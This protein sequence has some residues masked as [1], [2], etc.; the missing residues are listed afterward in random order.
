MLG[1]SS[2]RRDRMDGEGLSGQNTTLR[3][4]SGVMGSISQSITM[5]QDDQHF[6]VLEDCELDCL[7]GNAEKDAPSVRGV[8]WD[9][10]RDHENDADIQS[11]RGEAAD[12]AVEIAHVERAGEQGTPTRHRAA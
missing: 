9:G 2:V 5:V 7:E 8:P 12:R 6:D 11:M 4:A 1:R 3:F 10:R